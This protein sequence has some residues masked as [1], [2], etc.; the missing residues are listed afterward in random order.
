MRYVLRKGSTILTV[1]GFDGYSHVEN[2]L[3]FSHP[4]D[5]LLYVRCEYKHTGL[6]FKLNDEM[7]HIYSRDENFINHFGSIHIVK[8]ITDIIK[9]E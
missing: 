6:E 5:I 7:S 8:K 2:V 3:T 1:D 9:E 4:L